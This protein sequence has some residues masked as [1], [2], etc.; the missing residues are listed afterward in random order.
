MPLTVI[1][2]M[3]PLPLSVA[4]TRPAVLLRITSWAVKPVTAWLNTTVK[5]RVGAGV[6]STWPAAWLTVTVSGGSRWYV[7]VLLVDA[8]LGVPRASRTTAAGTPAVTVPD[9]VMPL[10]VTVYVV[11]LPLTV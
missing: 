2:Y 10:T 1:V 7:T 9:W 8:A 6:G 4:V 3:V 5:V 11:P